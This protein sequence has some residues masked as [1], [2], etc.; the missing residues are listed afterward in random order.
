[1]TITAL[2]WSSQPKTSKFHQALKIISWVFSPDKLPPNFLPQGTSGIGYKK[3]MRA[4]PRKLEKSV[5]FSHVENKLFY[6]LQI[7]FLLMS[8]HL[9]SCLRDQ[10]A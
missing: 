10:A 8:T 2:T 6:T 4:V 5:S 1:L 7:D 3:I 9:E